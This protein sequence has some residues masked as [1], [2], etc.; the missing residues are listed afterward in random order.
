MEASFFCLYEKGG[1]FE[2]IIVTKEKLICV[3]KIS[4]EENRSL[5]I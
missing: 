5:R 4:Y 3:F 2:F 1:K